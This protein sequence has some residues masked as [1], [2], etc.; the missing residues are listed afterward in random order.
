[1]ADGCPD[2][3]LALCL[4]RTLSQRPDYKK[5]SLKA[6]MAIFNAFLTEL[7]KSNRAARERVRSTSAAGP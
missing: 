3:R 5:T 1:M 6:Q 2:V 4:A 7:E